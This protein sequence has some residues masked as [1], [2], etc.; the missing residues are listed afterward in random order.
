MLSVKSEWKERLHCNGRRT[1]ICHSVHHEGRERSLTWTCVM[2]SLGPH[3]ANQ[4]SESQKVWDILGISFISNL[5]LLSSFLLR[6]FPHRRRTDRSGWMCFKTRNNG[7]WLHQIPSKT[8]VP[9]LVPS[10]P[11]GVLVAKLYNLFVLQ[12]AHG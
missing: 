9:I 6:S 5:P 1:H 8:W 4:L 7:G 11:N 10:L 3:S 2:A 12:F